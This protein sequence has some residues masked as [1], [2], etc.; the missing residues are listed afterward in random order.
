MGHS[1]YKGKAA[2]TVEPRAPEF[3]SL[4]VCFTTLAFLCHGEFVVLIFTFFFVGL[5]CVVG[6]IQIIKGRICVASVCTSR[7]C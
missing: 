4:D 3:T 2:L 5:F 6:G 1:I 7:S